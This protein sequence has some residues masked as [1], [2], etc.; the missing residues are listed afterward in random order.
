MKKHLLLLILLLVFNQFAQTKAQPS[1]IKNSSEILLALEKLNTLGSVLYIAAHP[2]DENTGLMT[3][4]SKAKKYRTGYLAL[5]RGDG[6]QNLIGA[7]KGFEIGILRTQE[8]LQARRI[9]GAEQF[10]T[11]AIDFGYSKSPEET[12]KIWNKEEVL[13]DVVWVIRN[14]KPDVII[15]RFPIGSSG[16]HG[17]HTA[18]ALLAE[19]AFRLAGDSNVFPEQLKFTQPWKTKRIFWNNWRPSNEESKNLISVDIGEYNSQLGKSYTEI[20]AASRS[21]HKSQGFGATPSR[22][23]RKE[24]FQL[25]GGDSANKEVLDGIKTNWSRIENGKIIDE[26]INSIIK[27]FNP[28]NPSASIPSLISL[29][30]EMNKQNNYW[31]N[32][33]KKEL[34]NIIQSCAGIWMEAIASDYAAA[35]GD[36]INIKTTL[37]NRTN[38]N[39]IFDKIE[40]P[41]VLLNNDLNNPLINNV[42]VSID[43]KITLPNDYKIS[44]PYWLDNTPTEGLFNVADQ[45]L[46]GVAENSP[47]IPV[48]IHLSYDGTKLEFDI[49]LLYRWNDRVE[50]ELYRPFEVRPR[51]T[52]TASNNV[53]IFYDDKPKEIQIKLKNNSAKSI[54][55]IHLHANG[56][57]KISPSTISFDLPNKYDEEIYSVKIY[58]PAAEEETILKIEANTIG[59]ESSKSLVEISYPHISR[60]VYFPNS[61]IKLV[62]LNIKKFGGKIGYIMG[63]GDEIPQYLTELSYNVTLIDDAMLEKN[64]FE[65]FDAIIAGIRAYNT[66]ERIKYA[67]T[68]LMDYVKNGGTFIAQYNV[69]FGLQVENIGPHPIKLGQERI[70]EEDAKI[71]FIN[72]SHQLLNYPNKISSKDFEGW[73]QERGLYF[74]NQW[75]DKYEPIFSGHDTG[76]NNLLGSTLFTKFGKGVF[77]YTGLSW[78]RQLPAGVPGAYRLFVNMIS[79]G[80]Y[81]ES[82]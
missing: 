77:I 31:I 78:F 4:F 16:G 46:I 53:A 56:N 1:E 80:K 47:S 21:M 27:S 45:L 17:H 82:K 70:S 64:N 73:I 24:F 35:P 10:F 69:S 61:E 37:I 39:F 54:G 67:Q 68:R 18:S 38:T 63:S 40:F 30:S 52:S 57:W 25:A 66:R 79:A 60:Q 59:I 50:G 43:S 7:E 51:V 49:P 34:L 8:L 81:N 72:P 5:T 32:V 55:E 48:K 62:R 6:G 22:G 44:Q 3:Y 58:P 2:D 28:N 23:S 20:S 26:Q 15:T 19:E 9:D 65:Q 71:N 41:T 33:K 12:F 11:R 14:Y 75:D 29:Y 76:E 13:K 36:E 42:P 74:A